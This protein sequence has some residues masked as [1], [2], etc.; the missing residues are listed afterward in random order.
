MMRVTFD[1]VTKV[2][3]TQ[4][5]LKNISCT[6]VGGTIYAVTGA[7]GSGKSTFLRLAG[8]LLRPSHGK[9]IVE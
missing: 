9:V 3:G 8:H 7:N 5:V 4:S 6:L 1:D 2:F